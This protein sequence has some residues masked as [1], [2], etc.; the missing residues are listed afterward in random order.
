MSDWRGLTMQ[1]N[2]TYGKALGT[3]SIIQATSQ[4][5]VPDTYNLHSA[6][7]LQSWDRKFLYNLFFVYQPP[8]YKSQH[9]VVGKIVGGWSIADP[10]YRQR[11][12]NAVVGTDG[13]ILNTY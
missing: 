6:Y 11:I 10:E 4:L 12:P 2:L 9:G 8:F 7:G 1:T 5:T 3:G 13:N